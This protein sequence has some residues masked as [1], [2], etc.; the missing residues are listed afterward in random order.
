MGAARLLPEPVAGATGTPG[1]S[2]WSGATV[3]VY[4]LGG[5]TF[6]TV[7]LEMGRDGTFAAATP[8]GSSGWAGSTST[9]R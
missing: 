6:D 8:R 5:G 4:D 2:A 9:P 7:V 1:P 3:A